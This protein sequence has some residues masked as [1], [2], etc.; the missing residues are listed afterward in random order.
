MFKA[1][2]LRPCVNYLTCFVLW[3]LSPSGC[4]QAHLPLHRRILLR[5]LRSVVVISLGIKLPRALTEQIWCMLLI[6]V[7][8][9][10]QRRIQFLYPQWRF[11]YP[12]TFLVR[13]MRLWVVL[14]LVFLFKCGVSRENTPA[15]PSANPDPNSS[16]ILQLRGK[17]FFQLLTGNS[18]PRFLPLIPSLP[19]LLAFPKQ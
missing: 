4:S 1:Y 16:C 11:V 6:C 19:F 3:S 15:L 9:P 12:P 10:F 18:F 5:L 8:I 17:L 2:R 14:G 13:I 7:N